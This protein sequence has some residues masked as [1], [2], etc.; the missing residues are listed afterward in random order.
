MAEWE[1]LGMVKA[2]GSNYNVDM[3]LFGK[4]ALGQVILAI[5]EEKH[6]VSQY[7][8]EDGRFNAKGGFLVFNL[9]E[10]LLRLI[11]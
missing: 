5:G 9:P 2:Y 11:S 3:E 4:E 6:V 10:H 1:S 7:K 8:D